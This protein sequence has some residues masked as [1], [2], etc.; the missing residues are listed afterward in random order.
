MI[1]QNW[2]MTF[3]AWHDIACTAPCSMYSVLYENGYIPDPFYATNELELRHLSEDDCDFYTSFSLSE[4][5]LSRDYHELV[6]YG[7]DTICDITLNGT[8]LAHVMNM[9]RTY[10]YEVSSLLHAGENT[11]QLHFSSPV[12]YFR[13]MDNKHY[14]YT[15]NDILDG[16]AHLRKAL[17]MSGWDW[18]P[19]L[20]DM[21]IFRPV[22][23]CSYD[24]DKFSDVQ[25]RQHHED[26]RVRLAVTAETKHSLLGT[27]TFVSVDGKRVTLVNGKAEI[28]I[29]EPRLWWPRGYGEQPLYDVELSLV[30]GGQVIDTC[31][32]TIGLRTLTLSTA[33]VKDGSEFCFVVNGVKIFAKGANY[34]PVDN[35]LPRITP[36]RIQRVIDDC[37]FANFNCIRVWGG[38]Y[39]PEDCFF[40]FCDR[41][42]LIV[43]Q[44]FMCA[45]ISVWMRCE[46]EKEMI[47]EA[48]DNV[49][50]I[51]HHACLGLLCG[52]NEIEDMLASDVWG[53]PDN[54]KVKM[55]YL[56][57]FEGILPELCEEYA[58]DIFYLSSS[59]TSGGGFDEPSAAN[60]GDIHF[61]EVWNHGVPFEEY[62]KYKFRFCSEYG[63]E[64]M[65]SIKTI[66]SFCP[67]EERNLLS[68]TMDN[69]QKH[70]NGNAKFLSYLASMYQMPSTLE[71][72]VYATQLNQAMAIQYGVE[73]F[74][75]IRGYCMGSIYWQLNDCWPVSSWSSIDYYGRYKALHY[76]AKKF[77]AP[78]A[79]GLFVEDDRV[80]INVANETLHKFCG[81][82]KVG[83]MTAVFDEIY[84]EEFTFDVDSLCSFDVASCDFSFVAGS[85][86]RYFYADLYDAD[87]N[88]I[89]RRT[90]LGTKPKHFKL[91]KPSIAV[92]AEE[93]EGGVMLSLSSSVLAKNVELSFTDEDPRLSDN[94]FDIATKEP[95]KVFV[96][97][98]TPQDALLRSLSI[99]SVYDIPFK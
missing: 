19:T 12:K 37:C 36:K 95:V 51:R 29:D 62:R 49:K 33:K 70:T 54:L 28:V 85:R 3:R 98:Q 78:V 35:L 61:W 40:D 86:E 59:P 31:K 24:C 52:N 2:K 72:T 68:F 82:V 27:S 6:F 96:Q 79:M 46:F 74:R 11:L 60:R 7:L 99:R 43:W 38:A 25:I 23:L 16:A 84:K 64:S 47:G 57:L 90:E 10:E 93:V 13:E 75:R 14:L 44:D 91:E 20:P 9:H 89:M 65:P 97:T 45:C 5:E 32:K 17:Y 81:T 69:H 21:G 76:F 87:G 22:E 66:D 94:F 1:L 8:R 73:H 41:A 67:P 30:Y 80:I 42:G 50:R 55:D 18:G 83:V 88:F 15:P 92:R 77:Y 48:I 53:P 39:Y 26:G 4:Q 56:R 63:F 58:P 34:I 71:G